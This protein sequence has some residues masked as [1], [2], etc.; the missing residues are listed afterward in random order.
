MEENR[1][2]ENTDIADEEKLQQQPVIHVTWA[3][4]EAETTNTMA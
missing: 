1:I 2:S 4:S 3:F